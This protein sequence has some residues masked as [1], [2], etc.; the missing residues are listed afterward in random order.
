MA[1][2][3]L[4]YEFWNWHRFRSQISICCLYN[5]GFDVRQFYRGEASCNYFWTSLHQLFFDGLWWR[6]ERGVWPKPL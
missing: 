2:S 4:A 1:Y 3:I 6:R 5:S